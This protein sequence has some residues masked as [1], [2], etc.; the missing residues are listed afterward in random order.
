MADSRFNATCE[1]S[2]VLIPQFA[3]LGTEGGLEPAGP[4]GKLFTVQNTKY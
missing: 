4:R 2:S 3:L 1:F